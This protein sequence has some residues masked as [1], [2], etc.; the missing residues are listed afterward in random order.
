M[1]TPAYSPE[2]QQTPPPSSPV[3]S[4]PS[5]STER[6]LL[7]LL[8]TTS[9]P[10]VGLPRCWPL[11]Y[12]LGEINHPVFSLTRRKPQEFLPKS[13]KLNLPSRSNKTPHVV[14]THLSKLISLHPTAPP[15]TPARLVSSA[16]ELT[17]LS[18]VI[19]PA[20]NTLKAVPG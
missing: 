1:V 18:P 20:S 11:S 5:L 17:T 10:P 14:S 12:I 7:P 8:L 3:H 9:L 15:T 6:S 4:Q 19:C 13:S 2:A 16:S